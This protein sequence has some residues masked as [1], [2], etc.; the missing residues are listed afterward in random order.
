MLDLV[1]E[2]PLACFLLV[3]LVIFS[4]ATAAII[5]PIVVREVFSVVVASVIDS[6]L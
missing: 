4:A 1:R 5:T 6:T 3:P 2:H